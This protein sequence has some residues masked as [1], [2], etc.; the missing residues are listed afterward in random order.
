MIKYLEDLVK[1]INDNVI[2]RNLV[3]AASGILV[4]VAV[5]GILLAVFTRHG[6]ERVV[7]QFEGMTIDEAESSAH[8][9]SMKLVVADSLYIPAMPGGVIIEQA[10]S[11][12]AKV[13]SGRKVFLT[14]NSYSQREAVIPYVA[15][16]SLRQAKNNL[17]VA[18]FTIDRL[19]YTPDMATNNVLKQSYEGKAIGPGSTLKGIVG[20]G[21]MLVV[22]YSGEYSVAAVPQVV[23]FSLRDACSRLWEAG[24]NVGKISRDEG[25][26]LLNEKDARVYAQSPGAMTRNVL[27]T[28]VSISITL[29]SN[30]VSSGRKQSAAQ[31]ARAAEEA[32]ADSV[33]RAGQ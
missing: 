32:A 15:G 6:Q 26:D 23:G 14:V 5:T 25:I 21:V 4:L 8:K 30:K 10:P 31:A 28:Q 24:F 22:G 11:P 16:Y 18:G 7:P 1:K 3:L 33:A 20:S 19:V 27:G 17:E 29:D 13:K 2:A 12:G 9:A